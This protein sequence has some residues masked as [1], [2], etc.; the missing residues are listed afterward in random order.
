MKKRRCEKC[1]CYEKIQED[2]GF[3]HWSPPTTYDHNHPVVMYD[4]WCLRGFKEKVKK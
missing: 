2:R 4:G 3:C 1:R